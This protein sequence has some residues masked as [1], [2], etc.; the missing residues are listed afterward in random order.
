MAVRA[1]IVKKNRSVTSGMSG[2]KRF[3]TLLSKHKVETGLFEESGV[4]PSKKNTQQW[5]YAQLM[6]FHELQIEFAPRRPIFAT[7]SKNIKK[8]I[9]QQIS[10]MLKQELGKSIKKGSSKPTNV[11]DEAGIN[12]AKEIDKVFGSSQLAPNSERTARRKG[13]NSPMIESGD[14]R[15]EI[16]Y[17]NTKDKRIKK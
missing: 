12:I 3:I 11:L 6:G 8:S 17:R 1:K 13:F 2:L 15:N 14:L 9:S 5:T 4:H 10:V 7:A 16:S